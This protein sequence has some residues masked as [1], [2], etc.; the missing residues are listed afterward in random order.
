[1]GFAKVDLHPGQS[2]EVTVAV[3]CSASN[4]PFSY[5]MPV[6]ES[7]LQRWAEGNW[8]TPNGQFTVHVGTSSADTPLQSPITLDLSSCAVK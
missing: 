7:N 1:M 8:V 4:H 3:D 2:E 5:F 6:D